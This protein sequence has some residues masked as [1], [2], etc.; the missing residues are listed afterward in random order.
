MVTGFSCKS[1]CGAVHKSDSVEN[2]VAWRLFFFSLG[3]LCVKA[4][5]LDLDVTTRGWRKDT[6]AMMQDHES[7]QKEVFGFTKTL[8]QQFGIPTWNGN[9]Y[10]YLPA[11]FNPPM[12]PSSQLEDRCTSPFAATVAGGAGGTTILQGLG[13]HGLWGSERERLRGLEKAGHWWTSGLGGE[14]VVLM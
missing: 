6:H 5:G 7:Q 11:F 9:N 10:Q 13:G 4:L 3:F 14:E 12:V 1:P 2:L 8:L